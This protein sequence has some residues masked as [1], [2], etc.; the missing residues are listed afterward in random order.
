[1]SIYLKVNKGIIQSARIF[2]DYFG[3]GEISDVVRGPSGFHLF[4]L[5]GRQAA[6]SNVPAYEELR[7]RVY[8]Q[9]MEEEMQQ[10][11]RLFIVEL[12]RRAVIDLRL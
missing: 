8:Q 5:E 10:Q 7:M 4:L 1:V 2:G 9:M 6:S 12:R 11:E 3:A